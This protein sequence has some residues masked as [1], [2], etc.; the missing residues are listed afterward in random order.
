MMTSEL[1]EDTDQDSGFILEFRERC[2]LVKPL[3]GNKALDLQ[4]ATDA[5]QHLLANPPAFL[6]PSPFEDRGGPPAV[7]L[8][9]GDVHGAFFA[10]GCPDDLRNLWQH[11]ATIRMINERYA[12]EIGAPGT[13]IP[14]GKD[15]ERW[16]KLGQRGKSSLFM[17]SKLLGAPGLLD[18]DDKGAA[19]IDIESLYRCVNAFAA[20]DGL[21]ITRMR[22]EGPAWDALVPHW[23]SVLRVYHDGPE[24]FEKSPTIKAIVSKLDAIHK[25]DPST[26]T[27][28]VAGNLAITRRRPR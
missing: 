24:P 9:L 7:D 11:R 4:K 27:L 17:L 5:V 6:H 25:A 22:G 28:A 26:E 14:I 23:D 10:V 18:E 12:R 13:E 3:L 8:L 20:Q 16:L 1:S 15:M 19:P 21:D 2:I